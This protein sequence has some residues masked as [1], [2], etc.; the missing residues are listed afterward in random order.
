MEAESDPRARGAD[1]VEL[2]E[3]VLH[4]EHEARAQRAGGIGDPPDVRRKPEADV[5]RQLRVDVDVRP[6]EVERVEAVAILELRRVWRYDSMP[7]RTIG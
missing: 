3:A 1:V 2:H 5:A 7:T 6:R 4:A